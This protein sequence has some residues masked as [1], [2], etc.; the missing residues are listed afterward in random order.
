M[1]SVAPATPPTNN[2]FRVSMNHPCEG[3]GASDD[4]L[5]KVVSGDVDTSLPGDLN[6]D[7]DVDLE[8]L[9]SARSLQDLLLVGRNLI[10]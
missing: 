9:F 4:V 5:L 1:P 8:D 6:H 10:S 2:D 7:G 3:L